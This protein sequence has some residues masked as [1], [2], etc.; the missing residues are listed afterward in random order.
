M[1]EV[2]HGALMDQV[3]RYQRHIY[4]ITRKYYLLGRDRLISDLAPGPG[5]T[6]LEIGVGTGRNLVKAA[7]R[8]PQT[9]FFGVDISREMLDTA[10][11][12]ID[13]HD[14]SD[15]VQIDQADA[16][17]FS[18]EALF[19]QATFARVYFSYTLSM[20]PDWRAAL[21]QALQVT[22][23]DGRL[24]VA[25][26]GQQ[27]GLPRWT[28]TVLRWWLG[29]FHVDPQADLVDGAR[30]IAARHGNRP[31]TFTPRYRG[32]CWAIEIGP[33]GA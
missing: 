20:I 31:V 22:A 33:R 15:R 24:L 27:E 12:K 16:T 2:P 6:V 29:L 4:D 19:D 30:E 28:R 32:Y 8:Y 10:A 5:D 1:A 9:P 26:F 13:R 3:Y 11:H 23:P 18:P 7:A 17:D 14:L 25:D 21:D